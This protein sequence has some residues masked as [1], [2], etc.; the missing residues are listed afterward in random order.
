MVFIQY[1]FYIKGFM[2][3]K[4]KDVNTIDI[5]LSQFKTCIKDFNNLLTKY[6]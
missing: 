2:F 5:F 1:K 3:D 6:L 4:F